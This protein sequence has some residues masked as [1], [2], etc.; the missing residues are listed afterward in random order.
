MVACRTALFLRHAVHL[1]PGC[2][3]C[4]PVSQ[5]PARPAIPGRDQSPEPWNRGFAICHVPFAICHVPFAICHVPFTRPQPVKSKTRSRRDRRVPT[6]GNRIMAEAASP[7]LLRMTV[8]R[9]WLGL[10]QT[11]ATISRDRGHDFDRNRLESSHAPNSNV[12]SD[13]PDEAVQR[14][15]RRSSGRI[16][17]QG[18]ER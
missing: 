9:R 16:P 17:G 14:L 10:R 6:P 11:A 3:I 5:R 7:F 13:Q 2:R 12:V 4:S 1:S 8:P 15:G 18:R